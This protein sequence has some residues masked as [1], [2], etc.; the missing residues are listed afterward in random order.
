MQHRHTSNKTKETGTSYTLQVNNQLRTGV[1][2]G[3]WQRRENS[4][5]SG[6]VKYDRDLG[7]TP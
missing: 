2:A 6:E 7:K 3:D 5:T 1:Q 4:A